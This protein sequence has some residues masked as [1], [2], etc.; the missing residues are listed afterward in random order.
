MTGFGVHILNLKKLLVT[1]LTVCWSILMDL[2]FW[3]ERVF[4][5]IKRFTLRQLLEVRSLMQKLEERLNR[6]INL[7]WLLTSPY[8]GTIKKTSSHNASKQD[9]DRLENTKPFFTLTQGPAELGANGKGIKYVWNNFICV[10]WWR[11]RF[12]WQSIKQR[13]RNIRSGPEEKRQSPG[14]RTRVEAARSTGC[15]EDS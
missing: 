5:Q 15:S 12:N 7:E 6:H 13:Y 3:C 11:N 9:L 14:I 1:G 4:W 10:N 8:G 2:M